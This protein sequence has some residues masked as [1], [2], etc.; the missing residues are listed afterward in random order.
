MSLEIIEDFTIC[1]ERYIFV[2]D[3]DIKKKFA[4]RIPLDSKHQIGD[5][6]SYE[7]FE[8]G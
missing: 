5:M 6:V 3:H 8:D 7:S 4:Y 2:W 1:D